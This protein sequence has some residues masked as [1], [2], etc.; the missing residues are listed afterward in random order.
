MAPSLSTVLCF[1]VDER[2]VC[3]V[4]PEDLSDSWYFGHLVS[5]VQG[6][7]D[8]GAGIR[9]ELYYQEALFAFRWAVSLFQSG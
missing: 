9:F 8:G 1:E 2:F 7:V 5:E 3:V 6:L 4:H